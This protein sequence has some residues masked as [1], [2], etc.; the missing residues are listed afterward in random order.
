[1]LEYNIYIL[2]SRADE[3][4]YKPIEFL[5]DRAALKV[6]LIYRQIH[7]YGDALNGETR[8]ESN[9]LSICHTCEKNGIFPVWVTFSVFICINYNIIIDGEVI[10]EVKFAYLKVYIYY[11]IA[12]YNSKISN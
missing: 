8:S 12:M 2:Q 1:M 6:L 4:K 9:D 7:T 11:K 3:K 10:K 5:Y